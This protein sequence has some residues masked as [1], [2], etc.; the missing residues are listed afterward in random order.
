[1]FNQSERYVFFLFQA[2]E[3]G[4]KDIWPYLYGYKLFVVHLNS[5]RKRHDK[6]YLKLVPY[7]LIWHKPIIF[8]FTPTLSL[9]YFLI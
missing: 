3:E 4:S 6:L 5:K 7:T 9:S 2:P 1:M 8:G